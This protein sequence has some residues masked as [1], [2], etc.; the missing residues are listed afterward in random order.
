M[1]VRYLNIPKTMVE[2]RNERVDVVITFGRFN[3]PTLGHQLL[4]DSL[5]SSATKLGAEHRVY[6][7]HTQDK[8]KNPLSY[9]DK[10]LFMKKFFSKA[11]I[12]ED[13]NIRGIFDALQDCLDDGLTRIAVMVGGDRVREFDRLIKKYADEMGIEFFKTISAGTRDPD[14]DDVT[15]MSASKL[16]AAAAD[17]DFKTFTSGLPSKARPADAKKLYDKVRKGLGISESTNDMFETMF[18]NEGTNSK[19][20]TIVVL[21][22]DTDSDTV[23]R[24]EKI[25]VKKG[26]NLYAV[27]VE[28]AFIVDEDVSDNDIIIHNYNGKGKKLNLFLDNT[29]VIVRGGVLNSPSGIA[30]WKTLEET[31]AFVINKQDPMEFCQNK[32]STSLGLE[33]AGLPTPRT[34]MVNNEDAIDTSLKKVGGKFPVIIKTITGAEGIGVSKVDS[35]ESLKSVLQSLWKFGASL[36]LQEYMEIKYDI[37]SLVLDGKVIASVKR[38]KSNNKDFRTNKALGNDT[39]PY[40]MSEEEQKLVKKAANISGCFYAGVDHIT[41]NGKHYL[42]EV[43]GSP[44]SGA[45]PY[46]GYKKGG[47]ISSDELISIFLEYTLD[48]DNWTHP[49][50]EVGYV[51]YIELDGTGE[52]K[53]RIDTGNSGYCVAH[54]DDVDTKD[55]KITCKLNG[56]KITKKILGRKK[57]KVGDEEEDRIHVLFD[58]KFAGK[59]YKDVEFT[60]DNRSNRVYPVL[61]GRQFL[62]DNRYSVNPSKKFMMV[63]SLQEKAPPDADMERFIKKK[64]QEFID[65]YGAEKGMEILY[66]T[67]WKMYNNKTNEEFQLEFREI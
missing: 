17:G 31:G 51:E 23:D 43:N 39:E 12:I 11:N 47:P 10:I 18:L 19:T 29:I 41:V 24:M 15:G 26:S 59:E 53:A 54:V 52:I 63:E 14:A 50:K 13:S 61:V 35:Y 40:E 58:V 27:D 60:L 25:A 5:K 55:G 2:S 28:K 65:Q 16:R 38:L 20:P 62:T 57:V 21:T 46:F 44:G 7:G 56:K 6:A 67:A 1:S 36:L 30:I 9:K 4:I 37:R 64:K 45:E 66:A 22:S 3:P 49:T 42:L 34:A 32:F 48:K 33:L 8:K